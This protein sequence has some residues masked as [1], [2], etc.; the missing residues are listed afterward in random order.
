MTVPTKD[1]HAVGTSSTA[2]KR[3]GVVTPE[4]LKRSLTL[5]A[6]IGL[7]LIYAVWLGSGFFSASVRILDIHQNTPILML[8]LAVVVTLVAGQFDLSVGSM[9][10][11]TAFLSIGLPTRQGWPMWLT[12][13]VCAAVGVAGG[14]ANG[15]LVVKL[16]VNTFIA[17]LA[18]M[19]VLVGLSN[20]YSGGSAVSQTGPAA[21]YP[22][23]S[24]FSGPGSFGSFGSKMPSGLVW[25]GL[26]FMVAVVAWHLLAVSRRPSGRSLVARVVLVLCVAAAAIW[27]GLVLGDAISWTIGV[28]IAVAFVT[29]LLLERVVTGRNLRAVGSNPIA[30]RLAG[31]RTE[32]EIMK[33]FVIGG[34]IAAGAG[35]ISAAS[36]GSAQPNV[37]AG[38]LLP[39]FT[40]A[41]L[42]TVLLSSGR[43][44]VWGTI[45]GGIFV[46]YVAQGLIVAGLPFTWT[47]VVNGLVLA[48]AVSLSTI[49]RRT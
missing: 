36:L 42:S 11:L 14:L 15:I 24:W 13:L 30:A 1:V 45:A 39:A 6:F 19:G 37:G 12:L 2:K 32:R 25:I 33:A 8:G 17:T 5:I 27:F 44:T 3:P 35:V 29:W 31:V 49:S 47:D 21:I 16:R 22:L 46:V 38:Y 7:F 10:T 26:V 41:F 4:W 18:T 9:A 48:I 23:P 34:V 20:V 40:A 43:F 28:L